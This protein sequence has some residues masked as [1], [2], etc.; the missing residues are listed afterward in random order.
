MTQYHTEHQHGSKGKFTPPDM[1]PP[2]GKMQLIQDRLILPINRE[3]W[4]NK[5]W[6]TEKLE[7]HADAEPIRILYWFKYNGAQTTIADHQVRFG[8]DN[9]V[10]GPCYITTDR[11]EETTADAIII[12][13]GAR[14]ALERVIYFETFRLNTNL[15]ISME[16]IEEK[17]NM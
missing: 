8:Q 3:H 11:S 7:S 4:L 2:A 6:T 1:K 9:R 17:S 5:I 13:N 14:T 15:S 16:L 10:C 12:S